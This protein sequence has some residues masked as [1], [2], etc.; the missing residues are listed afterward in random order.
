MGW[1][2]SWHAFAAPPHCPRCR[3][4]HN[5]RRHIQ[6]ARRRCFAGAV[7]LYEALVPQ[8]PRRS[9]AASITE[10]EPETFLFED[11]GAIPNS[12]LPL[13]AI[14]Q[15][16]LTRGPHFGADSNISGSASGNTTAARDRGFAA[17]YFPRLSDDRVRSARPEAVSPQQDRRC[18]NPPKSSHRSAGGMRWHR[19]IDPDRAASRRGWSPRATPR[20]M[21]L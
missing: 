21:L 11:E 18:R 17:G 8:P 5:R 12:S 2:A 15:A 14:R 7:A 9:V 3:P 10:R 13:P 6:T 1:T 16:Q 19:R 4:P 20:I